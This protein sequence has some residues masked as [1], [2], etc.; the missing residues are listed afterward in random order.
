MEN[1]EVAEVKKEE[2][3]PKEA[4]K[5]VAVRAFKQFFGKKLKK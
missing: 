4:T 3:A 5:K 1:A 2:K